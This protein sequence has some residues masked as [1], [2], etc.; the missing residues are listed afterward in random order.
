V[1]H[2]FDQVGHGEALNERGHTDAP[3]ARGK[4]GADD[5][6][7]KAFGVPLTRDRLKRFI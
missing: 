2:P 5:Y 4:L 1:G 3:A 6:I 7:I